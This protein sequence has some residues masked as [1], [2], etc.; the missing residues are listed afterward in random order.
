MR[1]YIIKDE[2]GAEYKVEELAEEQLNDEDDGE[3]DTS[4]LQLTE[5]EIM[6]LKTLATKAG[7]IIKLLDVEKKE[8]EAMGIDETDTKDED[9]DVDIDDED[10]DEDEDVVVE[11]KQ[12][13]CDSKSAFGKVATKRVKDSDISLSNDID[14]AWQKRY[15]G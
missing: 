13:K 5:T 6:A 1:K 12:M 15:G 7:A 3:A 8:H 4:A 9:V 2:D 14:S 10:D 11:T